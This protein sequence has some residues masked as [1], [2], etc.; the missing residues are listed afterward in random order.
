MLTVALTGGI[1]A[2]KSVVAH[3]LAEKGCYVQSS[4]RLAHELMKPGRPAWRQIVAH[5]GPEILNP[6][7]TVN[8]RRLGAIVFNSPKE[9]H[10]MNRLIHP[11]VL[12]KKKR[13]VRVL[14]KKG[15]HKIFVSEAALTIES[16]FIPFFDKVIVVHCPE[17]LQIERLMKR[18][19][20][21]RREAGQRI[22]SQMPTAEKIKR[23]DYLIETSGSLDDTAAQTQKV[24]RQ[25]LQDQRSKNRANKPATVKM[26]RPVRRREAG[27]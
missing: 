7:K 23:A 26:R 8:R 16:G 12:A 21:T 10:F 6:D 27:S 15:A 2:G 1:A 14:E 19:G 20:I 25:L 3:L 13:T 24:Y 11:L 4:D 18:D 22:R 9:R 5:F 17:E